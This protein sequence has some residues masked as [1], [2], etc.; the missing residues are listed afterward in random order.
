MGTQGPAPQGPA[1]FAFPMEKYSQ[2]SNIWYYTSVG[3]FPHSGAMR[4]AAANHDAR[5]ADEQMVD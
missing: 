4:T 5:D 1:F 2:E 3:Y